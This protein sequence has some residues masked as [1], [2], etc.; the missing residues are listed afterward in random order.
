MSKVMFPGTA[1]LLEARLKQ[2]SCDVGTALCCHPHPLYGGS[3]DDQVVAILADVVSQF[4]NV[5]MRFNFRGVG[6]SQ[7]SHDA[8]QGE[9]DDVIS[10][11]NWLEQE[12]NPVSILG[13]YS[14]G[15]SM[16]LAASAEIDVQTLILIAPPLRQAVALSERQK[17]SDIVVVLGDQDSYMN[18]DALSK[19]YGLEKIRII[20]GADHFFRYHRVELTQLLKEFMD[21]S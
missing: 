5:C 16:A 12:G 19:T 20:A 10:A 8:G 9:T 13:G 14:F 18:I 3:L 7:G 1:G 15:A 11:C 2:G 17:Q 4:S 6:D 21:G